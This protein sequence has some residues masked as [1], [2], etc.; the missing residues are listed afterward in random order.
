MN[1]KE[2][3]IQNH[4]W[5]DLQAIVYELNQFPFPPLQPIVGP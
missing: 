5:S 3:V 1:E 4:K 2:I